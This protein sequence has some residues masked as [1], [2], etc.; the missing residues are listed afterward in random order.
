M[1]GVNLYGLYQNAMSCKMHSTPVNL[2]KRDAANALD[3][4]CQHRKR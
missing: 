3:Y 1:W 4:V 2:D